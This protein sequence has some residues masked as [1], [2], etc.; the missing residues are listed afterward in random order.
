MEGHPV[1]RPHKWRHRYARLALGCEDLP[2]SSGAHL[3][4]APVNQRHGAREDREAW[5]SATA[6]NW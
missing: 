3:H 5:V 4:P 1:R 2:T 6:A